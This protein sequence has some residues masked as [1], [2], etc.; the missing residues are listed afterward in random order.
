MEATHVLVKISVPLDLGKA[1]KTMSPPLGV[2]HES[3]ATLGHT[4]CMCDV[5]C[6]VFTRLHV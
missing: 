1:N 6:N 3:T 2:I 4:L 5:C